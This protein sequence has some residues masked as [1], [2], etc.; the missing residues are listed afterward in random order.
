MIL[1]FPPVLF[2]VIMG[3]AGLGRS[4]HEL[5]RDLTFARDAEVNPLHRQPMPAGDP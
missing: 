5:I 4:E 2:V 3:P 1:F